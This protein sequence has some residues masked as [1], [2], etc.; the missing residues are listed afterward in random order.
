M[1]DWKIDP[2]KLCRKHLLGNHVELHMFVGTIKKGTSIK[3][4]I[5]MGLVEVHNI[6]KRH[7]E[8]VKE[9]KRR[10]YNHQSPLIFYSDIARG[11]I[12]IE[13]NIVDLSTRC[14]ECS[15]L[16]TLMS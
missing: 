7:E 9:L 2:T 1:R 13:K 5:D 10:G 15:Q 11:C 3:G 16:L 6:Q 8:I 12:N 14:K 4:Y